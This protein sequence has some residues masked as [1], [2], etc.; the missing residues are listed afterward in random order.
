[1]FLQDGEGVIFKGEEGVWHSPADKS[2]HLRPEAAER[3]LSGVLKAY[4]DLG[5]K[6]LKEVFL[7]CA[8]G[9]SKEEFEGFQKACPEGAKLVAVRVKRDT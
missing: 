5:G 1:M 7:H 6:P 2:F 3:L 4:K 8:S 9:I